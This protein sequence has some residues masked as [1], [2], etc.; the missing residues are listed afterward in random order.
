MPRETLHVVAH[1]T[2]RPGEELRVREAFEALVTPTRAEPGCLNY[3]LFVYSESSRDFLF[4]QEYEDDAAFE[5]HL[6]SSHITEMLPDV[7]PDVL[8]LSSSPPDIRRYRKIAFL[9]HC[10]VMTHP[11]QLHWAS[12]WTRI[13]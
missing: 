2:A 6:A 7:L 10:H 8:P 9:E 13:G 1:A 3:E 11:L 4:V 12:D 5:A